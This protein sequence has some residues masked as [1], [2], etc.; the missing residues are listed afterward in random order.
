L[1]LPRQPHGPRELKLLRSN[2][3]WTFDWIQKYAGAGAPPL[4]NAGAKPASTK[5]GGQ[6][7]GAAA[8]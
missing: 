2:A 4:A 1:I 6:T 3:Q 8:H 5:G 7:A